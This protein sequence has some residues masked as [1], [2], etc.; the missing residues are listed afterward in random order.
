[1]HVS[2]RIYVFF[3]VFGYWVRGGGGGSQGIVSHFSK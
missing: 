3:I 1:M 2:C